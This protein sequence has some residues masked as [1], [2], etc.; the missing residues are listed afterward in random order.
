MA[1]NVVATRGAEGP[2]FDGEVAIVGL[3][4]VLGRLFGKVRGEGFSQ[5][6]GRLSSGGRLVASEESLDADVSEHALE[7]DD[8][9]GAARTGRGSERREGRGRRLQIATDRVHWG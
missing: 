5:K 3:L 7:S 9:R 6:S 2:G 8:V 4:L 1:L